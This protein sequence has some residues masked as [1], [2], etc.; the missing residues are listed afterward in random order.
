MIRRSRHEPS[1]LRYCQEFVAVPRAKKEKSTPR[2][3][4]QV[5]DSTG[6]TKSSQAGGAESGALCVGL[7]LNDPDIAELVGCWA[8]LPDAVRAGVVAMVRAAKG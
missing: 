1:R 5:K 6:K 7:G 2:G 8:D 3:V 4:E